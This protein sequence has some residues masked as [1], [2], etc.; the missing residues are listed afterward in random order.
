MNDDNKTTFALFFILAI[1]ILASAYLLYQHLAPA[2]STFCLGGEGFNCDA[3]NKSPYANL[4]GLAYLL[5]IDL[6]LPLPL[7]DISGK[8]IIFDVLT[9]NA[10]LGMMVLIAVLLMVLFHAK[11]KPLFGIAYAE[12]LPTARWLLLAGVLYGAYLF[13]IQHFILKKYCFFC[14]VL[15]GVLIVAF[16]LMVQYLKKYDR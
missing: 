9:S 1:G 2:G 4:D 5:T 7:I 15:D 3:V 16:V 12:L 13:A 11:G 10:F 14:L 6:G 8:H